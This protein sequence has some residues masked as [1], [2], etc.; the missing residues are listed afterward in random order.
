MATFHKTFSLTQHQVG[1]LHMTVGRLV[2]GRSN[3]LG[4]YATRHV[5]HLLGAL[6]NEQDNHVGVG[7]ILRDGIRDVLE[8]HRLTSLGRSHD[9]SALAFS[10]RGKHIHHTLGNVGAELAHQVKLLV[11]EQRHQVLKGHTVAH[12][13]GRAA[14]Y[15][16]D[17]AHGE[18]LLS[19]VRRTN[20]AL[21]YIACLEAIGLDLRLRHIDIVGRREVVVIA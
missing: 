20:S 13:I 17:I 14:I 1:N 9:E 11:G 7:M 16:D 12:K 2:E 15:H 3:H 8:K 10:Y 4:V 5:G 18:I 21:H 6:V 19:L